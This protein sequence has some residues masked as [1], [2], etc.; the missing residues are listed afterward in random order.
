MEF[1]QGTKRLNGS[2]GMIQVDGEY[3]GEVTGVQIRVEAE[4]A[5]VRR[6]MDLDAKLV[7]RKGRGSISTIRAYT[8]ARKLL[9]ALNAGKDTGV[10]LICWV[11]DPDAHNG[12]EERICIEGVKFTNLDIMSFTHG[13]LMKGEFPFRFAPAGLKY[14]DEIQPEDAAFAQ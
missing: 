9:E 12:Q 13:E 6:G 1:T 14:L 8:R 7:G 2:F 11:A 10:R 3:W 4:Y 5:D